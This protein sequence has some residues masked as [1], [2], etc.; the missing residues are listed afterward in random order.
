VNYPSLKGGVAG[1][2]PG[3]A[4]HPVEIFLKGEVS[5]RKGISDER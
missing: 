4:G 5:N 3:F 2:V 1:N